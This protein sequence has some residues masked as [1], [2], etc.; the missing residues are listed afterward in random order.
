VVAYVEP[1]GEAKATVTVQ[2]EKLP[3]AGSVEE[4]RAFWRERLERLATVLSA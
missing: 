2:H 3:D 1:K 4:M